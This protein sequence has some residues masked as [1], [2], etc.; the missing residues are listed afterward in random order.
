MK[1]KEELTLFADF[2]QKYQENKNEMYNDDDYKN[3]CQIKNG[4]CYK[5]FSEC[6]N[7]EYRLDCIK[8]L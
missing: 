6:K 2:M 4:Y 5:D 7:C 8:W 3:F 1:H